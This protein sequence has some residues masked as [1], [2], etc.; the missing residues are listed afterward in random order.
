MWVQSLGRD[1]PL[2]K[3]MATR[4]SI[5]AGKS[6][7]QR[8]LVGLQWAHRAAKSWTRLSDYARMHIHLRFQL[9]GHPIDFCVARE[10]ELLFIY[11]L[12]ASALHY[13]N[14]I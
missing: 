2:W 3:E 13:T 1:D 7:G 11:Q 5:L 10:P 8:G 14:D 9:Y 4:C 12:L 6:H